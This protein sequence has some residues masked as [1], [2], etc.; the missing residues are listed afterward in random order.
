LLTLLARLLVRGPDREFVLGD[1]L[2]LYARRVAT[3][4][5]VRATTRFIGETL[6]SAFAGLRGPEP[7]RSHA[8]GRRIGFAGELRTSAWQSVRL[9]R[10][11]PAF[12]LL[13]VATLALGIGPT[14]TVFGVVD[15]LLMRPLPGATNSEEAAYL[16]LTDPEDDFGNYSLSLRHFDELRTRLAETARVAT[17]GLTGQHL[18]VGGGRPTRVW[19]NTIHGDFFEVL[20]VRPAEGRLIGESEATLDSNPLVVVISEHLRDQ[21]FGPAESVVGR[22][23]QMVGSTSQ[24]DGY[25]VEIVGVAGGGFRGPVRGEPRDA[26]LPFGALVPLV[27]FTLARLESPRSTMHSDFIVLPNDGVSPDSIEARVRTILGQMAED[28]AERRDELARVRPSVAAGLHT[29]P[30]LRDRNRRTLAMMLSVAALLLVI[31]CANVANLLLF[32][33]LARRGAVA[34]RRALGA[35]TGQ[36]ARQHM[37]GGLVL[38]LLGGLAGLGVGWLISY[39]FTGGLLLG[40]PDVEA[41]RPDPRLGLW[42]GC[43]VMTS[44]VL[45][46]TIPAILAGRFDLGDALRSARTG[47]TGRLGGLRT[48][49]STAQIGLT[50]GLL[51]SGLLVGRTLRNL[52]SFPTGVDIDGVVGVTVD[53][54]SGLQAAEAHALQRALLQA[55]SYEVGVERAALDLFGPHGSESRARVGLPEDAE[56]RRASRPRVL[57]W[58]VS[59]G[60]FDLFGVR[61]VSGRVFSDEDWRVPSSGTAVVTESLARRLFGTSDAVGRAIDVE[62]ATPPERTIVGVT[63]DYTSR[64]TMTDEPDAALRPGG[65][66]DAVFVPY[67]DMRGP[68]RQITV[69]AK[70]VRSAKDVPV[71]LKAAIEAQLPDAPAAEPWFLQDR[72]DRLYQEERLLLHL[73]S[74]LSGFGALLAGVGLFGALY[75]MTSSRVHEFAIRAALGADRRRIFSIVAGAA[76]WIVLLGS[77]TGTLVAIPI[78]RVLAHRLFGVEALD[79]VSYGVAVAAVI[80]VAFVACVAP[81]RA[82]CGAD[83]VAV[84][85]EE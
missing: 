2:E 36:L 54:P 84:L 46:S 75:Y 53:V 59:P 49:L 57:A 37:V 55:A 9:L 15:Q 22:T 17:Y 80:L 33:N 58:Q 31:A 43:A 18:S 85:R 56:E 79:P 78:S 3:L 39:L 25:P 67:G 28:D 26:W 4:G 66:T 73:L 20:G 70:M 51:V 48:A 16:T 40:M 61:T 1:L 12:A 19:A 13:I 35:T 72:V 14:I 50:L 23:I 83:P 76:A 47:E 42:I 27:G 7:L 68:I 81:A 30:E 10:R 34:T 41:F 71:R 62:G 77:I 65:P 52:N 82:A 69:F 74:V 32:Q 8:R 6:V 11:R 24:T 44:V 21:L 63:A 5:R 29:G 60:W 38:G 64:I 45:F